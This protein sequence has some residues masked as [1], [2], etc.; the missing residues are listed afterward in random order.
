MRVESDFLIC[1][2]ISDIDLFTGKCKLC[3]LQLVKRVITIITPK[4]G[5]IHDFS[6]LLGIKLMLKKYFRKLKHPAAVKYHQTTTSCFPIQSIQFSFVPPV[7][8]DLA[9]PLGLGWNRLI[10][11]EDS[12]MNKSP[13]RCLSECSHSE[14]TQ[15]R[16]LFFKSAVKEFTKS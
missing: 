11:V 10:S 16:F 15:W 5:W 3:S 6:F 8:V 9:S 2:L 14:R 7:S 13:L 1:S 4:E 12:L